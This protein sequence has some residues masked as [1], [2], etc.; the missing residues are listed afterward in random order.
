M[1]KRNGESI[2][3]SVEQ[4]QSSNSIPRTTDTLTTLLVDLWKTVAIGQKKDEELVVPFLPNQYG[5]KRSETE[6][7]LGHLQLCKD[8]ALDNAMIF[9]D[10]DHT[11]QDIIKLVFISFPLLSETYNDDNTLEVY[12]HVQDIQTDSIVH[13]PNNDN[14]VRDT[15]LW[16]QGGKHISH[17]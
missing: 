11:K 10:V 16:L 6:S 17:I 15:Q 8:C 9:T 1:G 7:L 13:E 12:D 2:V 4:K 14:L 5:L 3:L